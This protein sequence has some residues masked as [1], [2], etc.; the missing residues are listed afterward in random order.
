M[1]ILE[2]IQSI[3]NGQLHKQKLISSV[4]SCLLRNSE[5]LLRINTRYRT[6]SH[7]ISELQQQL[8]KKLSNIVSSFFDEM[9]ADFHKKCTVYIDGRRRGLCYEKDFPKDE[10]ISEYDSFCSELKEIARQSLFLPSMPDVNK[11]YE[12]LER[13]NREKID[14]DFY[15]IINVDS[16]FKESIVSHRHSFINFISDIN[17]SLLYRDEIAAKAYGMKKSKQ[18]IGFIKSFFS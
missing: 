15:A 12:L 3:K 9:I 6:E 10:L 17:K 7:K 14:R 8:H 11:K 5:Q 1:A 4:T 2:D 16:L 18:I 13:L